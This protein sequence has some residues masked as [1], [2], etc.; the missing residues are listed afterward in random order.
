MTLL[1]KKCCTSTHKDK[2]LF[3]EKLKGMDIEKDM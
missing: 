2:I 3:Y 1:S